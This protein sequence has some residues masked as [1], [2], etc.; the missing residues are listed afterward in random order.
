M[1]NN[2]NRCKIA[3]DAMG[4]DH[5]PLVTVRGAVHA[6]QENKD[7]F[8]VL[9]VGQKEVISDIL[10]KEDLDFPSENIIDAKEVILMDDIPTIALKSKPNSSLSVCTDLV[11]SGQAH[12]MV[13][14]GNTGAVMVAATFKIGRIEGISR[15]AI[16]SLV[17]TLKNPSLAIDMG[18]NSDCKPSNLLEFALMGSVYMKEMFGIENPKVGLLSVGEEDSKGN[19]VTIQANKLLRQSNLNFY[20]NIEGRDILKGEVDVIVCDG[21]VG[22]IVLKFAEGFL[23]FLLKKFK[24]SASKN[25]INK[26]RLGLSKNIL[27]DILGVFDY[28]QYGGIPLLGVNGV[29]I[30][31]HG[32]SSELAIKNMIIRAYETYNHQVIDRI[33]EAIKRS[34]S[35]VKEG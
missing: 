35:N 27:K 25:L 32:S 30:I 24:Q 26:L 14:A 1:G 31:G 22:N 11:K 12:A 6:Y 33:S 23:Y 21:F 8:D 18:A 29:V 17:P 13:S 15:P 10:D 34:Q 9:I 3:L 5:A 2:F 19:E 20:G 16:A 28:Q 7:K 4:G